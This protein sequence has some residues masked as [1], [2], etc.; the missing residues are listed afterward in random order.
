[1]EDLNR[2]IEYTNVKFGAGIGDIRSLCT[3]AVL[4]K[5]R[6]VCV[7]SAFVEPAYKELREH[8]EVIIVSTAGFPL[9]AASV[10]SKIYE[11]IVAGENNAKEIDYVLNIGYVKER[12]DKETR[13]EIKQIVRNT[14]GLCEVKIIIEAP[15][16]TEEEIVRVSTMCAEEGAAYVKTATGFHGETTPEMVSLIRKTVEDKCRIKAAGGIKTEEDVRKMLRAGADTIGTSTLIEF[17]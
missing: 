8:P 10:R 17:E 4:H 7:N 3:Q 9:G 2:L 6:A 1:M 14:A 16:L 15:A 5:Y 11:A 12:K 13:S